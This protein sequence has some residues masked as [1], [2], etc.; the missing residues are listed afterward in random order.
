MG[1]Y[2]LRVLLRICP[3]SH[4]CIQGGVKMGQGKPFCFGFQGKFCGKLGIHVRPVIRCL[5]AEQCAFGDNQVR[6]S[7]EFHGVFAVT[8]IGAVADNSVFDFQTITK[9]SGCMNKFKGNESTRAVVAAFIYIPDFTGERKFMDRNGVF[10]SEKFPDRC[11]GSCLPDDV[12]RPESELGQQMKAFYMVYMKMAEK[13]INRQI[14]L[15]IFVHFVNAVSGVQDNISGLRFDNRADSVAATGIK[16]AVCAKKCNFHA[17]FIYPLLF[18][19][20]RE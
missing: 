10:G 4:G 18:E 16:P 1:E 2:F 17:F 8:C 14:L 19:R 9:T 7:G 13:Q 11:S 20:K 6:V 12:Q 5:P 3:F 15:H